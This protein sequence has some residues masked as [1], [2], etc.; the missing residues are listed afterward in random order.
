MVLAGDFPVGRSPTPDHPLAY[1]HDRAG[2]VAGTDCVDCGA[3]AL[4]PASDGGVATRRRLV[5]QAVDADIPSLFVVAEHWAETA[6]P[7]FAEHCPNSR[8]EVFGG[9]MMFWEYAERFNAVL[10]EF[11]NGAGWGCRSSRGPGGGYPG[12]PIQV[13]VPRL[14]TRT[15][16]IAYELGKQPS[17]GWS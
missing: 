14:V 8:V 2:D 6:K 16:N 12:R 9:H 10:A 17:T 5:R 15:N 13:W 11:L 1:R 3:V 7:Y 4:H